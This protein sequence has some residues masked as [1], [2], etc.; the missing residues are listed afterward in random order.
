MNATL[1][2]RVICV[3]MTFRGGTWFVKGTCMVVKY[4]FGTMS[5]PVAINEM[6]KS[7][8]ILI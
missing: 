7:N 1:F 6:L 2:D 4:T 5:L 3:K 8:A